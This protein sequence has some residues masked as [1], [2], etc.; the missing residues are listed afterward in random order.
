[1]KDGI[2]NTTIANGVESMAFELAASYFPFIRIWPLSWLIQMILDKIS[3]PLFDEGQRY[4]NYKRDREDAGKLAD[5]ASG[6]SQD[7]QHRQDQGETL[8]NPETRAAYEAWRKKQA[9]LIRFGGP[10]GGKP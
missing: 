8:D 7:L 2:I 10:A 3:Q 9:D 1:M 6:A 4:A 5:D